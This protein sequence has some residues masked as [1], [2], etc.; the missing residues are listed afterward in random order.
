MKKGNTLFSFRNEGIGNVEPSSEHP[1]DGESTYLSTD[2][3]IKSRIH[4]IPRKALDACIIHSQIEVLGGDPFVLD[5]TRPVGTEVISVSMIYSGTSRLEFDD[6]PVF[7]YEPGYCSIEATHAGGS[8]SW[9]IDT[10]VKYEGITIGFSQEER[11]ETM[12]DI[13]LPP[14]LAWMAAEN[15]TGRHF[16]RTPTLPHLLRIAREAVDNPYRGAAK[17]F[18]LESKALEMLSALGELLDV[19]APEEESVISKQEALA[20]EHVRS[21]L[22][23][24]LADPPSIME[25]AAQAGM[26]Y[27]KLVNKFRQ[28]F[29]QTPNAFLQ[30]R[31]L[32][33]AL[34]MLEQ[35]RSVK[36]TAC[37][38]GYRH[39]ANFIHAFRRKFGHTPGQRGK[40]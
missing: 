25:L 11:V 6:G 19:R 1:V 14:D 37:V 20:L 10:G 35:G 9:K 21:R 34:A 28:A 36:E 12:R 26:N 16:W 23:V 8:A 24:Q 31:R 15:I 30:E 17:M 22:V 39:S 4:T 38:L 33:Q 40:K 13:R 29:N 2:N 3:R 18:F 7:E 27:K 5:V 32:E